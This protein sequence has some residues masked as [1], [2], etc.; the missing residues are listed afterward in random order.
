MQEL[1]VYA[2]QL[3][4]YGHSNEVIKQFLQL[5]VS[6]AQVYRV[7]DTYGEE[8]GKTVNEE[9]ALP[10]L[11]QAEVLYAQADGSMILTRE[12]KWK[13]V[14]VGRLFTSSACVKG[15]SQEP[16]WIRQSQY[17]AHLGDHRS[18]IEQAD[19]LIESYGGLKERLV[20]ISDGA[21]WIR[22]WI[23]DTFPQAI[24][25][26]DFYHAAQYLYGFAENYFDSQKQSHKWSEAQKKLL[27]KSQVGKVMDNIEKLSPD[28]P[29]AKK[30]LEYYRVNK[31]RMDYKEYLKIGCGIIGSGAIESAHRTVVQKRLKLSGQRW[32]K[33][34]AQ[35]M[36]NLRVTRMNGQW[37]K[38]VKL[39]QTEFKAAA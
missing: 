31:E 20:F 32:T 34:G 26:L 22:N 13:E 27:L 23:A 29:M 4:C 25:I 7:T 14:K 3:D 5:E 36:L 28:H 39:V 17:I 8:V 9:K 19:K 18:F 35:N 10:A 12:E 24:S 1:M 11:K 30:V 15:T 16:G 2:G 33:K 38:L 21:P 6:A 37:N